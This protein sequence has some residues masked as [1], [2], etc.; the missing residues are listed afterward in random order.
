MA[1]TNINRVVLTGNLTRDP[2]LRSLPSGMSVCSLRIASNTRRKNNSTGEWEDKPNYFDVTVWG[3]QGE[4]CARFLAKGRPVAIDGRLEWREWDG[5][6][7]AT[8]AR[9]RDH[10]RRRAVPRRP[11][12]R[13]AVAAA[14]AAA[15]P[16]A[17]TSR[18]TTATSSPPARPRAAGNARPGRRRH[19][20]LGRSTLRGVRHRPDAR[21]G[22]RYPLGRLTADAT[23]CR[24]RAARRS[25]TPAHAANDSLKRGF[26]T[27][28]SSAAGRRAGVTEGRTRRRPPQVLPVLPRQ[29]RV[30]RLQGHRDPAQV[31]LR[32][33]Q[34]PLAPHHGRLPPAPEP[35]RHGRQ[36]RARARAAAVRRRRPRGARR[37]RSRPRA[38]A[39]GTARPPC[40]RPSCCR[41]SRTLGERGTVVDVSKGYLRNFLIPRKLAEP[42]TKG[43]DR[44]RRAPPGGRRRARPPSATH[45]RAGE[46]RRCSTRPCS[47]S[48]TRPATTAACSARSRR[49]TSSTRSRRPAA[50]RSTA[51]RSTSTSR[52]APSARAWS[53]SRSPTGVTAT[54]RPWSS[55]QK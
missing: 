52:S 48:R 9:R 28:R 53:T 15:S 37:A 33:R 16:R 35:D 11:R 3:A 7:T 10:R 38:T 26:R 4:N 6:R 18:S 21:R 36:A 44:R 31:H 45:A 30:R 27:W 54:S 14:R 51:A 13:A 32:P 46:R 12:R 23:T 42:A 19:P 24:A 2:E 17:R 1:A 50:S 34:D 22:A 55:K 29:G 43:V 20:V 8:S 41:T 5:R 39:T 49:R 40:R 25:R 47:R